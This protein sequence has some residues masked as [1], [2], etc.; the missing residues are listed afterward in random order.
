MTASLNS[1][2][3]RSILISLASASS[4]SASVSPEAG[5]GL[6]GSLGF[7]LVSLVRQMFQS[8][9]AY[10][11]WLLEQRGRVAKEFLAMCQRESRSDSEKVDRLGLESKGL[12]SSSE[13]KQGSLRKLRAQTG[14]PEHL[15]VL[16][17]NEFLSL[18]TPAVVVSKHIH[19]SG[20]QRLMQ[21]LNPFDEMD[22]RGGDWLSQFRSSGQAL[23]IEISEALE[24]Y[25]DLLRSDWNPS[26]ASAWVSVGAHLLK[27]NGELARLCQAAEELVLSGLAKEAGFNLSLIFTLLKGLISE[28]AILTYLISH[29]NLI[30]G[31]KNWD[32]AISRAKVS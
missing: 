27:L 24:S 25:F 19:L 20:V 13:I 10:Q 26:E 15:R 30:Y 4:Q 11:N 3:G 16:T 22:E 9:N 12:L 8:P 5:R 17:P 28:R 18:L 14:R 6:V 31:A 2:E 29:P 21:I 7:R 32:E 23:K 1:K